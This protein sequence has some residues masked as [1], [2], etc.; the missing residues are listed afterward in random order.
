MAARPGTGTKSLFLISV[1]LPFLNAMRRRR[2]RRWW[3]RR[4]CLTWSFTPGLSSSSASDTPGTTSTTTR[5]RL[6]K[7][8]K[9]ESC[10]KAQVRRSRTLK[11]KGES[12]Q[13]LSRFSQFHQQI[14]DPSA[15]MIPIKMPFSQ[16]QGAEKRFLS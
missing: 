12:L 5:T 2:R 13:Y 3:W 10:S 4:L 1:S 11:G 6:S 15:L 14:N 16:L 9:P 7:R 8:P